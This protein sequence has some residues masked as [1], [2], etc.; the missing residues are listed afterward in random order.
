MRTIV[1]IDPGTSNG[2][3][4][5][6]VDGI[7][8]TIRN[9]KND[10]VKKLYSFLKSVKDD[11]PDVIV[12]IEAVN[13]FVEDSSEQNK[14]KQF[15][16]MEM[17]KNRHGIEVA[18]MILSIPYIL[19][20]P[21]SWQSKIKNNI[22]KEIEKK[23]AYKKYAQKCFPEINVTLWNSDALCILQFAFDKLANDKSWIKKYIK[24]DKKNSLFN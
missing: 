19:V 5:Y 23:N 15:R 17:V 11:H 1:A 21:R 14:G 16:I 6:Y 10:D 13:M 24:N 22:N 7:T 12:F 9:P 3:I 18:C 2:G 4:A 8:T 20:Y